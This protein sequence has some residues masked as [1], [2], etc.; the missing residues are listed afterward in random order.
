MLLI[1]DVEKAFYHACNILS[2]IIRVI[3]LQSG[4]KE[5]PENK[6]CKI[7]AGFLLPCGVEKPQ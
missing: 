6:L 5:L 1:F 2:P 4:K 7:A 3:M